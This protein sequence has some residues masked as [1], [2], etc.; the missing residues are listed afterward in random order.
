MTDWTKKHFI[1]P[2]AESARED[3]VIWINDALCV[4]RAGP[5]IDWNLILSRLQLC[6]ELDLTTKT[7][8]GIYS[9]DCKLQHTCVSVNKAALSNWLWDYSNRLNLKTATTTADHKKSELTCPDTEQSATCRL[10][11][12]WRS[13]NLALAA[14]VNMLSSVTHGCTLDR[15]AVLEPLGVCF[16]LTSCNM[17]WYHIIWHIHTPTYGRTSHG[18]VR[19]TRGGDCDEAVCGPRALWCRSPTTRQDLSINNKSPQQCRYFSII[20]FQFKIQ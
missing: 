12:P 15:R 14:T 16:F 11:D 18:T 9:C 3:S 10:C 5:C 8:A 1:S 6:R 2:T 17:S 4:I 20:L 7:M 19:K 13:L